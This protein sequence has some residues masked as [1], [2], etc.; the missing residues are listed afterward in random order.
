M[1]NVTWDDSLS[2][3][4]PLIDEQ[5]KALIQRLNDVSAA[6]EASQGEREIV[7]TLGFLSDYAGFHFS[8]EEKHMGEQGFPGLEQQKVKH[9]EFMAALKNL[10]QDFEEEGSTRALADSINTFL[11]NWLTT[12]IRGLD[13]QF[14]GFLAE[15]GAVIEE[16]EQARTAEET[17]ARPASRQG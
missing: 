10:E 3:G 12:H 4:V 15:K 13:H 8:T 1:G 2:I 14:A 11:L 17:D 9:Q 6:V 5:H 7:K 16:E